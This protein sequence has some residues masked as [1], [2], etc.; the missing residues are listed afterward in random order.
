MKWAE[1]IPLYKG[2]EYE[3]VVNYQ[4]ISLLITISKVLGKLIYSRV[5]NFLKTEP[6]YYMLANMNS[7]HTICANML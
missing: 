4:L 5:Y 2:K 1:V 3:L 7:D 6:N